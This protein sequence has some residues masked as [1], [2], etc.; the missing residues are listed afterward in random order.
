MRRLDRKETK[1]T[2]ET[3]DR[4]NRIAKSNRREKRK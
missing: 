1:K 2:V 4:R 3:G